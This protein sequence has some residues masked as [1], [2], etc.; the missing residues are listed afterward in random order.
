MQIYDYVRCPRN[1]MP[2][3]NLPCVGEHPGIDHGWIPVLWIAKHDLKE[4]DSFDETHILGYV[5]NAYDAKKLIMQNL[6]KLYDDTTLPIGVTRLPVTVN[7]YDT[8]DLVVD[9]CT[10]EFVENILNTIHSYG[11]QEQL[12]T[13]HYD[14]D[15]N[16]LLQHLAYVPEY[17]GYK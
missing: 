6:D 7:T 10:G 14:N 3:V 9:D 13:I 15:D 16:Q 2:P 17:G 4:F 8:Y 12:L 5:R 1:F 11:L